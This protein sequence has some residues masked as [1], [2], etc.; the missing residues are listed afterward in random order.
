M[1]TAFQEG[2]RAGVFKAFWKKGLQTYDEVKG[3][4]WS[5]LSL[6]TSGVKAPVAG[7][8]KQAKTRQIGANKARNGVS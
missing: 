1:T 3:I 6:D 8:K 2:R 7:E 5:W 4:N